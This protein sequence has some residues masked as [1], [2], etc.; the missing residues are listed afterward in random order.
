MLF[1]T[2]YIGIQTFYIKIPSLS[3]NVYG[4]LFSCLFNYSFKFQY[5]MNSRTFTTLT[6]LKIDIS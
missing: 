6:T 4:V 5:V 2:A 3:S 1:Y